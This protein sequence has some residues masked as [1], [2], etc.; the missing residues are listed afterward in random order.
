V[1]DI[2]RLWAAKALVLSTKETS[3]PKGLRAGY[4]RTAQ[5]SL[6]FYLLE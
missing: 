3:R 1:H 6:R 2:A 5:L 4:F